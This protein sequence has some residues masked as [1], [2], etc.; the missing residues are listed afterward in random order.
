MTNTR[1]FDMIVHLGDVAYNLNDDLGAKG[2]Q[3]MNMIQFVA[4]KVPYNF[5]IGN[6]ESF[7]NFSEVKGRFSHPGMN[8]FYHSFDVGP[9]HFVVFMTTFYLFDWYGTGQIQVDLL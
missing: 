8:P 4:T 7:N 6:H 9:I 1:Q 5:I 3:F 2:D